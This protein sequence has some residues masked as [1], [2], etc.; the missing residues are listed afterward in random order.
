MKKKKPNK[1]LPKKERK[2]WILGLLWR[3]WNMGEEE[4]ENFIVIGWWKKC[5]GLKVIVGAM[6]LILIIKHI[7]VCWQLLVYYYSFYINLLS[8]YFN[9]IFF[10]FYFLL[11]INLF[12]FVRNLQKNSKK[13]KKKSKRNC[14]FKWNFGM[15]Y[16][17]FSQWVR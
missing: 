2:R 13:K 6:C 16:L 11:F 7:W 3:D 14:Y 9:W 1:W 12:Y 15:S 5:F 17:T 4:G 8:W 10:M